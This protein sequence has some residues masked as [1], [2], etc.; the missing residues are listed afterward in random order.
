MAV[1]HAQDRL[2][3][4]QQ[5]GERQEIADHLPDHRRAPQAPAHQHREADVA[6]C[7]ARQVQPDVVHLGGRAVLGRARDG[8]LELAR[9]VGEFRVQGGPLA[10]DLAVGPRIVDL[11]ARDARHVIGGDVAHAVAAGLD[12]VHLHAG[13]LGQD[14]R[15]VGEIR[16]VQLQ[17]LPRGEVT[18]TA[19]VAARD[20]GELG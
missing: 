8:D 9:Q 16:P 10:D 19:V 5:L 15:D 13:E 14:V 6:P 20:V 3:I 7:I 18:I 11:V 2:Q 12:G 4:G 1:V 17:V